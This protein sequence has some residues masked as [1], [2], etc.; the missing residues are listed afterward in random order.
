[1]KVVPLDEHI[2]AAAEWLATTPR[3][4]RRPIIPQL[5]ERFGITA[6]EAIEAIR[7]ANLRQARAS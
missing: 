7:E 4:R 6:L 3:D 2:A 5:R 1:M